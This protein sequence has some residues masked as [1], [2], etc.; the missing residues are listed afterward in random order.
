[1][2]GKDEVKKFTEQFSTVPYA[3]ALA[4]QD[5]WPEGIVFVYTQSS[6]MYGTVE[7]SDFKKAL[8]IRDR[9]LLELI[10]MLIEMS[11]GNTISLG[12]NTPEAQQTSSMPTR[13][14]Q[15]R[16]LISC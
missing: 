1:M 6:G 15:S 3:R 16:P 12:E 7:G 10:K 4:V 13:S 9:G 14:K 11:H 8:V 5:R 2:H